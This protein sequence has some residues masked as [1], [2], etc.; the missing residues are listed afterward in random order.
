MRKAF[1]TLRDQNYP[2]YSPFDFFSRDFARE[3]AKG[4]DSEFNI[5]PAERNGFHLH[6]TDEAYLASMDIPGVSFSDIDIDVEKN[7]LT[8]SAERKNPLVKNGEYTWRYYQKLVLPESVNQDKINAHYENGVLSLT[9]PKAIEEVTK[10]KIEVE[11]G[12]KPKI[13]STLL[14]FGKGEKEI[15][16]SQRVN[17][18]SQVN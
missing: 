11:T 9:L 13:W 10:K 18:R 6:E 1:L 4:M 16:E 3:I 2:S 12:Q 7:M 15:D 17:R 14:N 8:I 5:A